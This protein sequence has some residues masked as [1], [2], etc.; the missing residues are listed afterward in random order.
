AREIHGGRTRDYTLNARTLA[1]DRVLVIGITL[2]GQGAEQAD[3][4]AAGG[5]ARRTDAGGTDTEPSGVVTHEAHGALRV[6]DG[7]GV[8]EPRRLAMVDCESR[9]AG[10]LQR[11]GIG[12]AQWRVLQRRGA[13]GHG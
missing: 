10:T 2:A 9:V 8:A 3:Q 11:L 13:V 1:V 6:L 12:D 5:A 4:M 7:S